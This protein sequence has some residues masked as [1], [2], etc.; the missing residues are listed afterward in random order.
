MR[1]C[2]QLQFDAIQ[3]QERTHLIQYK[4]LADIS[5]DYE[6]HESCNADTIVEEM[7]VDAEKLFPNFNLENYDV[8]GGDTEYSISASE[9]IGRS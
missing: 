2:A 3:A 8:L 6:D 9:D 4:S 7:R 1:E 5:I